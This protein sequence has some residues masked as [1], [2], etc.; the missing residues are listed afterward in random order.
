MIRPALAAK[1][2]IGIISSGIKTIYHDGTTPKLSMTITLMISEIPKLVKSLV[3]TDVGWGV[4]R[5][6]SCGLGL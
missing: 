2:K 6:K 4:M 1:K 5:S 3:K